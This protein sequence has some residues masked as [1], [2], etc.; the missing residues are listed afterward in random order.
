MTLMAIAVPILP[1]RT[2]QWRRFN[3]ELNGRRRGEYEAS[4]RRLGVRERA[5]L[6]TTPQGDLVIVTFEGDDP[7]G[8]FR[9]LGVGDDEFTRWFV[10]QVSEI[11]GMDLTQPAMWPMPWLGTDSGGQAQ[12]RAA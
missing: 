8:A 2:D 6:Q 7:E 1:G 10:Q 5:F 12:P 3:D 4:R 11:H 9:S